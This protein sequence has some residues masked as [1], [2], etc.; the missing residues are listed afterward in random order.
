MIK[1]HIYFVGGSFNVSGKVFTVR[2]TIEDFYLY[3]YYVERFLPTLSKSDF[4]HLVVCKI[5]M[6]YKYMQLHCGIAFVKYVNNCWGQQGLPNDILLE[7]LYFI[8]GQ[9]I[10]ACSDVFFC[11]WQCIVNDTLIVKVKVGAIYEHR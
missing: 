11:N 6:N 3:K 10:I 4:I 7:S 2:S 1:N 8:V 9:I 5:N